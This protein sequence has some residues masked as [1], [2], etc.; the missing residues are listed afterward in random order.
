MQ[1]NQEALLKSKEQVELWCKTGH[2]LQ[3]V[4]ETNMISGQNEKDII[5]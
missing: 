4:P 1:Q 2:F 5:H 3:E